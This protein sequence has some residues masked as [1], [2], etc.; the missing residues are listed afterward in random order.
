M[1]TQNAR[2][3]IVVQEDDCVLAKSS[4]APGGDANSFA[5]QLRALGQALEKFGLSAFDLEIRS[6]N[7]LIIA[8]EALPGH[9]N[10]SFLRFVSEFLRRSSR[11]G[12]LK[13]T[14]RQVDLRFSTEDI[15]RFDLHGKSRRQDSSKMPDPYSISQLLRS[16][17]CYLDNRNVVNQVEISLQG[18]WVTVRYQ[19]GEGR[20]AHTQQGLEYFYDYWVKM[21]LRRSNRVKLTAPTKP[22]VLV[23]WQD[24]Q[25]DSIPH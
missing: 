25:N 13:S 15:E 19:T 21:C 16:A 2:N 4:D 1:K 22:T 12:H 17:G 5:C 10:F 14:D 6:G 11:R 23:T 7:Y 20:L 3:E 9:V 8:K 24:I 18:R